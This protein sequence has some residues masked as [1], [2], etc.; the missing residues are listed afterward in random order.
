MSAIQWGAES[1]LLIRVSIR[2]RVSSLIL[3]SASPGLKTEA[4]RIERRKADHILSERIHNEGISSF[5]K[6]WEDIPLFD[7][8]KK[9]PIEKQLIIRRERLRQNAV[10][11]AN[12][13]LGIGTGSQPSY[14]KILNSVKLPVLLITGEIDKKFVNIAREMMKCLPSGE[15]YG[16]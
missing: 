11:L 8:Q 16:R 6:F 15:S 5:V 2:R 9:L 13:L 12:S 3:E 10:G 1:L 4:A 7:S 14:W